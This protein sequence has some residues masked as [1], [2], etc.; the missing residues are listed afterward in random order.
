MFWVIGLIW[1]K[2]GENNSFN[3]HEKRNLSGK[4][5]WVL[6]GLSEPWNYRRHPLGGTESVIRLC[7]SLGKEV[8]LL[9]TAK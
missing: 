5:I 6:N 7:D 2:G 4:A 9:A 1:I 8:A 3:R